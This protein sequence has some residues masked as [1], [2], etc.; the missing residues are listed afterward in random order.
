MATVY[1]AIRGIHSIKEPVSG[2]SQAA[3][4]VSFTCGAYTAASDNISIGA[5][6][7]ING[8]STSDTLATLIQN[9]RRDGKT[10][11]LGL[12]AAT[13]V[14]CAMMV[15]SGLEGSTTYYLGSFA[16]SS[17]SITCNIANSSGT[18]IDA[19]SGVDDRPFEII[20]AVSLS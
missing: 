10:V 9:T 2:G 3:Y 7:T 4:L 17:G 11:T 5:G 18:E 15:Q 12:P 6:G 16:I 19:A 14:N 8:A 13:N 1:A 20:V